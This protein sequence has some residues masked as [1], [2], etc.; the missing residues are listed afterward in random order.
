M[1]R[2]TIQVLAKRG[3]SQRQIA[4]ELGHSRTTIA[5]ALQ[6]PVDTQ[7][8]KRQ[9]ASQVDPYRAQITQW[10]SGGLSIVRMLDLARADP[11]T[12]YT[13][14]R[15]VFND[16]VRRIRAEVDRTTVDV[17]VRLAQRAPRLAGGVS[18]S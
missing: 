10:L 1:E 12:P 17:P 8:A 7:P 5:R 13:G 3:K 6:A 18:A 4:K 15:S 11:V 9:R 16:M 14:G 2:S